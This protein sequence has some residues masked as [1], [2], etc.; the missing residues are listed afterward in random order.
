MKRDEI[1][2]RLR[3][4]HGAYYFL[5]ESK[6]ILVGMGDDYIQVNNETFAILTKDMPVETK[7]S[8]K[9]LHLGAIVDKLHII[10]LLSPKDSVA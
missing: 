7:W 4:L 1:L 6:K 3:Q 2:T 8:G 5:S 10:T 9:Y